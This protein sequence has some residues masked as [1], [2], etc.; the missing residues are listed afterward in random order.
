MFENHKKNADRKSVEDMEKYYKEFHHKCVS[1][2]IT[3][4]GFFIAGVM[5]TKDEPQSAALYIFPLLI[6]AFFVFLFFLYY[7]LL[8][9]SR[10]DILRKYLI[11]DDFPPQWR[12]VHRNVT[13][14]FHG[15][16][17]MLFI[18]ILLFMFLALGVTSV[19]KF[20]LHSHLINFFY[21]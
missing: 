10:I 19:L 7:L 4:M 14:G 20:S 17:D 6:F 3:I 12:E 11:D 13:P 21:S 2:Y 15:A 16:G 18:L 5:A 9:S 1:W 8:Y